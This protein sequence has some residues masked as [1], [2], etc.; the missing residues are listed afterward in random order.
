VVCPEGV[1]DRLALPGHQTPTPAGIE[2]RAARIPGLGAARSIA[3]YGG[4]RRRAS[5]PG[6]LTRFPNRRQQLPNVASHSD[7]LATL[8][9]HRFQVTRTPQNRLCG[10]G[11]SLTMPSDPVRSYTH[12]GTTR[13]DLANRECELRR[14]N[15]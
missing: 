9:A 12:R 8:T 1:V 15:T 13:V 7:V 14:L 6:H 2:R 10:R 3:W 4:P 5:S 11:Q